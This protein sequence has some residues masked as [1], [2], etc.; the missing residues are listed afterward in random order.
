MRRSVRTLDRLCMHLIGVE[1][2]GVCFVFDVVR[3]AFLC[4]GVLGILDLLCGNV[5]HV[6]V[7]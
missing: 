7:L 6:L 5:E 3:R 2:L 1:L 4:T